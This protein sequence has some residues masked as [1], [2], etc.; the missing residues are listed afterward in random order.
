MPQ[1]SLRVIGVPYNSAGRSDG[2]AEAPA[3]LR[4]AGLVEGLVDAGAAVVDRGDLRIG[5]TSPGRDPVSGLIDP[6][7]LLRMLRVVREEVRAALREEAFPLVIGGD[8]PV[9]LGCLAA[10]PDETE[11]GL[12]F[13]DGHEDAWPPHASTTGEAADMELGLAL[14]RGLEDLPT[15]LREEIPRLDPDVVVVVGPRDADELAA[16]GVESIGDVVEIIGPEELGR[17][18]GAIVSGA[19]T[20]LHRAAAWWLHVD[21]DVLSSQSLAAVDYPQ[22][23]GVGWRALQELTTAALADPRIA[24]WD[25]TIY[26]PELDP[27]GDDARRIV[28]YIGASLTASS[29]GR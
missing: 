21:L 23:G 13:V 11:V 4:A 24:G 17:R 8:C 20:R 9:L 26:N 19:L 6:D 27:S 3:A 10:W 12:L 1:G 22:P 18:G 5:P 29:A 2:V 15:A 28:G 14:G 7:G 25:V 16:A